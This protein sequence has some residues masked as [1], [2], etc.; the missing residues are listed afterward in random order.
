M[1]MPETALNEDAYP[2]AGQYQIRT[3]WQT[4]YMQAV[5]K[6]GTVQLAAYDHF[7]ASVLATDPGHHARAYGRFDNIHGDSLREQR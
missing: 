6:T 5:T 4:A 3:T 2:P 1:T 7:R